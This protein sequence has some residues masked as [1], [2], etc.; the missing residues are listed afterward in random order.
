MYHFFLLVAHTFSK[1]YFIYGAV[2]LLCFIYYLLRKLSFYPSLLHFIQYL[3]RCTLFCQLSL[4]FNFLKGSISICYIFAAI[5]FIVILFGVFFRILSFWIGHKN[6]NHLLYKL[7]PYIPNKTLYLTW[8]PKR[9][10]PHIK[11]GIS[12]TIGYLNPI[13]KQIIFP[14]IRPICI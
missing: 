5:L 11:Q 6:F 13:Q 9:H 2:W 14:K 1:I 8:K 12:K 4:Q 3:F 10:T 7:K